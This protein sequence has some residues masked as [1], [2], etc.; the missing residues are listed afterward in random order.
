MS[1]P[2]TVAS[3]YAHNPAHLGDVEL[4]LRIRDG[5]SEALEE[6][7]HRY[8]GKLVRY[9]V[10]LAPSPDAAEDMVQQA[11]VTIWKQRKSYQC[12]G[13]P[14]AFLYRIVRNEAL[15]E[16][17]RREV[18]DRKAP[19]VAGRRVRAPTP[20]EVTTAHELNEA[21]QKALV[22]LP[23]RRREAF[24][25]SRY[26]N[27]SLSEVA[28]IMG[29]SPQTAANHVSLAMAELRRALSDFLN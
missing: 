22:D 3:G 1:Q 2:H 12:R 26:H 9:A 8:W 19:E 13:T 11:F 4:M 14:Q 5:V 29:V 10:R 28:D 20:L 23:A 15:Q 16:G 17:R 7:L 24:V 25:L 18:R 21:I 27:L 6:L